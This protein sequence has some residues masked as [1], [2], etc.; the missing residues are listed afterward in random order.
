MKMKILELSEN[1]PKPRYMPPPDDTDAIRSELLPIRKRI[2]Y[3]QAGMPY[4]LLTGCNAT[5]YSYDAVIGGRNNC[6]MTAMAIKLIKSNPE[7]TY[8]DLHKAMRKILPSPRYPQ[9]PQIEGSLGCKKRML[10]T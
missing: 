6:A 9:S 7:Q 4:V 2:L 8:R 5:E 10:F 3:P 1:A